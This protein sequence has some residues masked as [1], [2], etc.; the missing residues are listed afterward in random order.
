M[1][2]KEKARKQA[3]ST[4]VIRSRSLLHKGKDEKI[5]LREEAL[6]LVFSVLNF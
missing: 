2:R 6:L 4:G 3:S 1:W 5:K